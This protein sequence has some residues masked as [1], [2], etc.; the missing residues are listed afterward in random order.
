MINPIVYENMNDHLSGIDKNKIHS[1]NNMLIASKIKRKL[2]RVKLKNILQFSFNLDLLC[3]RKE[4]V[5][6]NYRKKSRILSIVVKKKEYNV[7][8]KIYSQICR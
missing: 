7:K 6:H 2:Y 3:N 5:H 8:M 1:R 4:K